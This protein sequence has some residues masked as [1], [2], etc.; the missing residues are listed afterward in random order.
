MLR[1]AVRAPRRS[2][3]P[4]LEP[5]QDRLCPAAPTLSLSSM[6]SGPQT[7]VLMGS[8][9]DEAPAGLTVN[10]T[11]AYKGSVAVNAMGMFQ[12]SVQPDH[13][14]AVNASVTDA[15][16]LTDTEF[17]ILTNRAP[18]IN[19]LTAVRGVGNL[20]TFSGMVMDEHPQGLVVTFGGLPALEGKTV[21]VTDSSGYFSLT[22]EIPPGEVGTVTAITTD[23]W[24]QDSNEALLSFFPT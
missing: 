21:T 3:V 24:D 10:F 20:W 16:G 14:G 7:Y 19:G 15:E 6:G 1:P 12:I 8:V 23:W 22:V 13:L 17:T 5:L 2:Y 9:M 4:F 18:T 11:G